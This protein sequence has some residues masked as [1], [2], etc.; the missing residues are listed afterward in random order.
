MTQ[1]L[2]LE[3]T[4]MV[5]PAVWSDL[6]PHAKRDA[7]VVVV[8]QMDLVEVGV[9]IATDN[10][11]AVQRWIGEQLIAKPTPAQLT[12]WSSNTQKRLRALI[13]QPYV[14]VQD[15]LAIEGVAP[16]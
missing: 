3:L 4:E 2:K 6:V 16:R 1:N 14:L 15:S 12:A 10:T 11:A 5:A 7:V 9:A 13:I 8:P